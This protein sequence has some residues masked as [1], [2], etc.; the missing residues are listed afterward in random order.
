[1]RICA[2]GLLVRDGQI[3]LA[4]R[5][6]DRTFYP[7]VWDLIGGHCE[8][9]EVPAEA[10]VREL[11][12]EVGVT[13]RVFDEIAVL[14]EPQP[15]EHG[16]AKYHIFIVTEWDGGEPRLRGPEHSDLRWLSLDR[17]LALPLAHPA[18]GEL[19]RAALGRFGALAP[20]SGALSDRERL[21][22]LIRAESAVDHDAIRSLTARAFAGLSFSDGTEPR[23][24]DALRQANA[25]VSSL[26]GVVGEQLIG[27]VAFSP[28]GPP[29]LQGWC[30]LGP[31]SVEPSFQRRGVGGQ[32]VEAGLHILRG[33]GAQGCVLVGDH[34]YYRRFGFSTAP[35][36]SPPEY[37]AEHF[38]LLP[39]RA[40]LPHVRVAF[41][42]A[43]SAGR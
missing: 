32:L 42:P 15:I 12:E 2:G 20:E 3:L 33:Q 9:D 8:R 41:H 13:A 25:L 28:V 1:M 34:R 16:E 21:P 36:F 31:L 38:Q 29:A 4:R 24:I 18:Y 40:S 14:P 22:V 10:L 6:A 35:A 26:V 11:E 23:I 17:A 43:F 19:F 30:A 5:S 7:G 39:F 37:P 27:H